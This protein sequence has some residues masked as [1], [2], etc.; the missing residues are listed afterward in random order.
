MTINRPNKS[1]C[2]TVRRKKDF[3]AVFGYCEVLFFPSAVYKKEPMATITKLGK[4][5][6]LMSDPFLF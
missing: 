3:S 2:A 1:N 4:Q 6:L 5:V